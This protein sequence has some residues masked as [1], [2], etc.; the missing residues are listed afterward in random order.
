MFLDSLSIIAKGASCNHLCISPFV[1]A[2][3]FALFFALLF[4]P[5]SP[6]GRGKFSPLFSPAPFE[7]LEMATTDF[8]HKLQHLLGHV[9]KM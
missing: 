9:G 3:L 2:D 7:A 6:K 5:R 4:Q 8:V 1:I